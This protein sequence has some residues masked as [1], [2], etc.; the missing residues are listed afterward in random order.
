[1]E[2]LADLVAYGF[3]N[4][5]KTQLRCQRM[6]NAVDDRKLGGTLLGFVQ[7]A[8]RFVEQPRVFQRHAHAV[9]ERFQQP[10]IGGR[11]CV[12]ALHVAQDDQ[13]PRNAVGPQGRVD[14]GHC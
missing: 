5:G 12:L 4:V 13:A 2:D 7:Q 10:H 6:L 8:L 9:G 1:M 14:G 11:E 3:V